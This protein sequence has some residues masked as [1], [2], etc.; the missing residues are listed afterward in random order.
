MAAQ[1]VV[2]SAS[3]GVF[4]ECGDVALRNVGHGHGGGGLRWTWGSFPA[5]MIQWFH[6]SMIQ[7][8]ERKS[9]VAHAAA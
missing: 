8:Y 2:G 6:D 5:V 1:G 3:L 7:S 9:P 4:Q